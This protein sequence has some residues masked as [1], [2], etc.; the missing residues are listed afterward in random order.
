MNGCVFTAPN[1]WLA[2]LKIYPRPRKN[3][4]K[5]TEIVYCC[6]TGAE[7]F[8]SDVHRFRRGVGAAAQIGP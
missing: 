8:Q 4:S 5:I 2:V 3:S 1:P 6:P 7:A